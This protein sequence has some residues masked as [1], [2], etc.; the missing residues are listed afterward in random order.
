[1]KMMNFN[2]F[3]NE[4]TTKQINKTEKILA[5]SNSEI[6]G[7]RKK[8]KIPDIPDILEDLAIQLKNALVK[9]YLY[10]YEIMDKLEKMKADGLS[11]DEIA[12]FEE[13]Q[14]DHQTAIMTRASDIES[15]MMAMAGSNQKMIELANKLA[16]KSK[17]IAGK[18]IDDK[19]K[20]L[21]KKQEKKVEKEKEDKK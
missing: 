9:S 13:L 18:E 5:K 12:K 19:M 7:D 1:M 21:V 4:A 15:Q 2:S 8:T 17:N 11:D 16:G 14:T 6:T 10:K 3:L 20:T